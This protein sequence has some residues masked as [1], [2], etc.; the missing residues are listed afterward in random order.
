MIAKLWR[1]SLAAFFMLLAFGSLANG[2]AMLEEGK[3]LMGVI[4]FG[5]VA[6][7]T[8]MYLICMED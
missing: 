1:W 4:C 2:I 8:M 6:F 7:A 3:P 5:G